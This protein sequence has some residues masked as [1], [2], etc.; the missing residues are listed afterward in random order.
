LPM[1]SDEAQPT[2]SSEE[3]QH[4]DTSLKVLLKDDFTTELYFNVD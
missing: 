3:V 1:S 2:D 4:E